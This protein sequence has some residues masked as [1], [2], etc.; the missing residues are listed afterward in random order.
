MQTRNGQAM[1]NRKWRVVPSWAQCDAL[2][3]EIGLM[4]S[5]QTH[6]SYYHQFLLSSTSMPVCPFGALPTIVMPSNASLALYLITHTSA[7]S[8]LTVIS[9]KPVNNGLPYFIAGTLVGFLGA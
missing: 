2:L 4:I 9:A 8:R 3:R 1:G 7:D 5:L 6:G